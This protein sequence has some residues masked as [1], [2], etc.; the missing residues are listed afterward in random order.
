MSQPEPKFVTGE[1]VMVRS[2]KT[3][4]Y[5]VD[6]TT[7]IEMV[8]VGSRYRYVEDHSR[9]EPGW[10]YRT[11]HLDWT[12]EL[13]FRWIREESLRKLPPGTTVEHDKA[14]FV[15]EPMEEEVLA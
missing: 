11:S 12:E 14:V 7:V 6:R 3:P 2:A 1:E 15:P 13:A 10:R 5:N 4:Q 9:V 8:Y